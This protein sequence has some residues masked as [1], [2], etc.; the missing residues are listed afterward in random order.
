MDESTAARR[1]AGPERLSQWS[2]RS[3]PGQHETATSS[4][5]DRTRILKRA[6]QGQTASPLWGPTHRSAVVPNSP[7][8]SGVELAACQGSTRHTGDETY[9]TPRRRTAS[10]S[11]MKPIR[12]FGDEPLTPLLRSQHAGAPIRTFPA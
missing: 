9:D 2:C 11:S 6:A 5:G 12:D 3:R 1:R 8:R 10:D 7:L 4:K